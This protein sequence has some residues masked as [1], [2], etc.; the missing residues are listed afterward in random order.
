MS[1]KITANNPCS[2]WVNGNELAEFNFTPGKDPWIFQLR[3]PHYIP[4]TGVLFANN[5]QHV[6]NILKDMW[7]FRMK[8]C[9]QYLKYA[10]N[11]SSYLQHT[12]QYRKHWSELA[13]ILT[14]VPSDMTLTIER[15]GT[16]KMYHVDFAPHW[17]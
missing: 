16:E 2:F 11:R 12:D 4:V 5:K 10:A 8:C 17:G 15:L 14:G 6:K 13:K 7:V 1:K 9:E 3:G